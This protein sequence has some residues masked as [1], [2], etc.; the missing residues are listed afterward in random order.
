MKT[1]K[2][3]IKAVRLHFTRRRG[4]QEPV[5]AL[6]QVAYG[7]RKDDADERRQIGEHVDARRHRLPPAPGAAFGA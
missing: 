3:A 1:V 6:D 7:K 4:P 2:A 5:K